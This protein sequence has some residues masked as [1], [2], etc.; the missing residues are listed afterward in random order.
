[1]LAIVLIFLFPIGIVV[2]FFE[3]K[4][5]EK[6]ND[7]FRKYIKNI[8]SRNITHDEKINKVKNLYLLN[9]Y[10][11]INVEKNKIVV[12]KK[13]V[14]FGIPLMLIGLLNYFGIIVFILYYKFMLKAK[15]TS[16]EV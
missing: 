9:D 6:N 12:S 16:I 11:I 5:Q 4:L 7:A 10:N 2:Y 1:M 8:Q 3:K 15:I 13:S 14:N